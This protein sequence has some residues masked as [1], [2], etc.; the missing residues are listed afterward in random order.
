MIQGLAWAKRMQKKWPCVNSW[1]YSKEIVFIF[2]FFLSEILPPTH[3]RPELVLGM[4]TGMGVNYPICSLPLPTPK[5][6]WG[7]CPWPGSLQPKHDT[8]TG[9]RPS[10]VIKPL[11]FLRSARCSHGFT[12]SKICFEV[13]DKTT[14]C[15]FFIGR[16]IITIANY[17]QNFKSARLNTYHF[18][19]SMGKLHLKTTF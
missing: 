3:D 16:K 12:Q 10:E 1:P 14:Q 7:G 17:C 15:I 2:K 13:P 6:E 11:Y 19:N 5:V 9:V 18:E 4:E 8:D